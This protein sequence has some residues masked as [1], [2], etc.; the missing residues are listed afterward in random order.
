MLAFS[1]QAHATARRG[2]ASPAG[3]LVGAG[4]ADALDEQ[5]VDA[6]IGIEARDPGEAAVD[7]HP[8]AVDGQRS[9][10]DVGGDDDL[11]PVVAGHGGVL[12]GGGEFA[13]QGQHDEVAS[14]A[15]V[16]D[17]V[18]RA[19]D[20]VASGHEDEHVTFTRM[21]EPLEL[22]GGGVPDR[23]VARR[24]VEVFDIHGK[25]ATGGSEHVARGEVAL[26]HGGI[27]RG[28]HDDEPQ[29]GPVLFLQ[30]E[31][32]REGDV[33]VEMPLVELVEDDDADAAQFVIG[34]HLPEQYPLGDKA[35]ARLRGANFVEP[36]LVTHFVTEFSVALLGHAGGEHP[37]GEPSRLEH[38]DLAVARE[39]VIED[40]LRDLGGFAGAGGRLQDEPRIFLQRGHD[41]G[42]EIEDGQGAAIQKS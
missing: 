18:D 11:A 25:G 32:A 3:A 16:G 7:D 29:V 9:F 35:D 5:R 21:G 37:G 33:P 34:E 22:P 6:A 2:A 24:F 31:G 4:A 27:E 30:I 39:P 19:A 1:P 36:D 10:R 8:D 38:D 26:Q 15:R 28:R 14:R 40:D 13:M 41:G 42:F 23:E 17:G 20:F 12:V